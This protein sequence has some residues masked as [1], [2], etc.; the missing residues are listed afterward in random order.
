MKK[1]SLIILV[2]TMLAICAVSFAD[3]V[4]IGTGTATT[5]NLPIYGYYNYTY[6]QQIYT[7]AQINK[8][9]NITKLRFFYVS[10]SITNSKDWVIYM[11]H[12]T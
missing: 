2:L 8:A 7:Q 3:I 5:S 11:G 1:Y 9:G 10:G 12:T 6:S 4:Q